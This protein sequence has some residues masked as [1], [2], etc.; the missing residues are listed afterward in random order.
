VDWPAQQK[1][2]IPF[3]FVLEYPRDMTLTGM[4]GFDANEN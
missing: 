2:E 1:R 4:D 3:S